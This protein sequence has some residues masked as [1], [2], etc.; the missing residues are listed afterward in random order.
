[1]S[2]LTTIAVC[3]IAASYVIAIA[4]PADQLRRPH[5]RMG[6][7]RPRPPLLG[8]ADAHLRLPRPRA[9]RRRRVLRRRA[10]AVARRRAGARAA[11]H[12]RRGRRRPLAWR[13]P[14]P[15]RRALAARQRVLGDRGARRRGGGARARLEP[16][17]R[18]DDRHPLRGVLAVRHLL[19]GR[20]RRAGAVDG[21]G[22]QAIGW[23]AGC[24]S[25]APRA[26]PR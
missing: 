18:R 25:P 6:G 22:L 23:T 12:R 10:A 20:G 4:I 16:H 24:W 14:H 11:P 9:V 5:D 15:C 2:T 1:M 3:W 17:P 21:A 7:G 26:T 8:R 19:R 13:D